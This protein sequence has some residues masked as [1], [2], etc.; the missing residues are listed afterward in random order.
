MIMT[1][2]VVENNDCLVPACNLTKM[3]HSSVIGF[4]TFDRYLNH[5]GKDKHKKV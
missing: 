2:F 5:E 3:Q 1:A 4:K